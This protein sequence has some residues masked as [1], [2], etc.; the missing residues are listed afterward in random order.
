[1]MPELRWLSWIVARRAAVL[2][3][4]RLQP[5]GAPARGGQ[6]RPL[7]ALE[8]ELARQLELVRA[9]LPPAEA[10][11]R[12]ALT[13][14][15][16]LGRRCRARL[17]SWPRCW[18]RRGCA[19]WSP[20]ASPRWQPRTHVL[21]AAWERCSATMTRFDADGRAVAARA[22]DGAAPAS[23]RCPARMA[24]PEPS[25]A[26]E[27][28]RGQFNQAVEHYNAAI[29]SS[30]RCCWRGCSASSRGRGLARGARF[31]RAS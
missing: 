9:R 30:R 2:V 8:A 6:C 18:P 4:R 19:R 25:A 27:I 15:A 14:S 26:A 31:H 21:L 5:P 7:P 3:R 28:A 20:Q 13:A 12:P 11:S 24:W 23:R 29:A 10:R 1:M 16:L 17:R 22:A